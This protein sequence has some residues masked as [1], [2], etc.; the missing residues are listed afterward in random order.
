M[1][2]VRR[3]QRVRVYTVDGGA[4]LSRASYFGVYPVTVPPAVDLREGVVYLIAIGGQ[5][6]FVRSF[7]LDTGRMVRCIHL[8]APDGLDEGKVE[9][10]GDTVRVS[11]GSNGVLELSL[12]TGDPLR[13][14]C[15]RDARDMETRFS[16]AVYPV[17]GGRFIWVMS[18][19][20]SDT[21]ALHDLESGR[22]V[23][24]VPNAS[25]FTLLPGLAPPRVA[26]VRDSTREDEEGDPSDRVLS[27]HEPG[28][29]QTAR[30]DFPCR[31]EAV[32]PHPSGEGLF[33]MYSEQITAEGE[34]RRWVEITADGEHRRTGSIPNVAPYAR[35][36]AASSRDLGMVFLRF[37]Q[38]D[39]TETLLAFA[40]EEGAKAPRVGSLRLA[41]RVPLRRRQLVVQDTDARRVFLVGEHDGGVEVFPLGP[42]PPVLP[43]RDPTPEIVFPLNKAW[44]CTQPA[45]N[46]RAIQW[47]LTF[48]WKPVAEIRKLSAALVA[49]HE[50]DREALADVFWALALSQDAAGAAAWSAELLRRGP[51]QPENRPTTWAALGD[52]RRWAEIAE[53]LAAI[54]ESDV[55]S[56]PVATRKHRH[57]LL[58]AARI[59]LGDVEQAA[60]HLE[61]A[62][63]LTGSCNLDP[64]GNLLAATH[65]DP[66]PEEA[67]VV[68]R[69][70]QLLALVRDADEALARGDHDGV[71][72]LFERAF[73]WEID[74]AQSMARLATAHLARP[75][76]TEAE[77]LRKSLA[78]ALF[79][80]TL[81]ENRVGFRTEV[82]V[83]GATWSTDRLDALAA[84][85]K[86]W[87][88]HP[89]QDVEPP[90]A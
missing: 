54:G 8:L 63:P 83:P 15:F 89:E 47:F 25:K 60:R 16:D 21:G 73:V 64:L 68:P 38:T 37:V 76:R 42:E 24:A 18:S 29:A 33:V 87:L 3:A 55:A 71:L 32:V 13:W 51:Y 35:A 27:L 17:P 22:V 70:R 11:G 57:H 80:D 75:A 44:D 41:Y 40:P 31:V 84:R 19:G 82:L 4:E 53:R 86:A 74:E 5:E 39:E 72:A 9:L 78:L 1:D 20:D 85:A 59:A 49:Q 58:A 61:E 90:A 34:R 26:V 43:D 79:A 48:K 45:R 30:Y 67:A 69:L 66:Q 23:R 50:G 12:A 7:A 77:R 46:G 56:L 81:S 52:E 6:I 88:E 65:A 10:S 36:A 28:G 14:S 2:D 62:R